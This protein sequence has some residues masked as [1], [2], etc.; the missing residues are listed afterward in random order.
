M[1]L[2]ALKTQD[3]N[4]GSNVVIECDIAILVHELKNI[5]SISDLGHN[6]LWDYAIPHGSPQSFLRD[7]CKSFV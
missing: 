3:F 5:E 7:E 6:L 2:Q 1:L 4:T